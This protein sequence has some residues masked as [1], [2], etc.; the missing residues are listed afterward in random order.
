MGSSAGAGRGRHRA[1][2]GFV[3]DAV[4]LH[5]AR[6]DLRSGQGMS[7]HYDIAVIGGGVVGTAI[8]RELSRF[9]LKTVLLEARPDLGDESSKGNSALMCSGVDVPAGTLE[10]HL[11]QRGYARY[12]AE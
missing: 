8:A 5:G 10:R 4:A 2:A 1:G 12:M 11:V 6:P 3:A 7:A 9:E